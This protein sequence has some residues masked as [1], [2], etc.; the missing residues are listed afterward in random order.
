MD[1]TRKLA[2]IACVALL[3][4]GIGTSF[5]QPPSP[6]PPPPGPP[7]PP[8]NP[9][10]VAQVFQMID[11]NKDGVL[12]LSEVEKWVTHAVT[13]GTMGE[14]AGMTLWQPPPPGSPP[15]PPPPP[16]GVPDPP[17]CDSNLRNSELMPQATNV[18]CGGKQGNLIFR[19]VCD[20]PPYDT[21][22]ITLPV[23]RMAGCFDIEAITKNKVVWGIR[24]E[25]GPDVYHAGMGPLA[26]QNLKIFDNAP[27]A[28]GKYTIYLDKAKS[29]PG[30]RITVRFVDHPK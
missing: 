4:A 26:L 17:M 30:A 18:P 28:A 13:P 19:T 16:G 22:A 27:S 29:D 24:V 11:A 23:G 21:V 14:P 2:L 15:P 5:A 7:P 3:C 20:N 6:P 10:I 12:Q 25:G 8:P 1:F 9:M